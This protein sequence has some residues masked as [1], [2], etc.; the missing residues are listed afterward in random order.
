MKW[1][2]FSNF[3]KGPPKEQS[4]HLAE[5]CPVVMEKMSLEVFFL[6]LALAAILCRGAEQFEQLWWRT[7]KEQ[8]YH[9]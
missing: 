4:Y 1:N 7:P 8:S 2:N 6:F 3:G 9:V 5:I